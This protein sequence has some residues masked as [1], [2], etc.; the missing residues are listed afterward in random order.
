MQDSN[1]TSQDLTAAVA[2]AMVLNQMLTNL[3]PG[4]LVTLLLALATG[5]EFAAIPWGVAVWLIYS[6]GSV[7]ALSFLLPR[8]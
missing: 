2:I 6:I 1:L 4:L 3:L 5:G 7:A 8:S